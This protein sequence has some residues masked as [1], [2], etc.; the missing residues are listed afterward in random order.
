[1]LLESY[2]LPLLNNDTHAKIIESIKLLIG[3]GVS[4]ASAIRRVLSKNKGSFEDLF[5]TTVSE[6]EDTDDE[7]GDEESTNENDSDEV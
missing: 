7:E 3:K 2:W 5:D 1:M 6:D 4:P